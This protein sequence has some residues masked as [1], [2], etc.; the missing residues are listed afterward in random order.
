MMDSG[1][2]KTDNG[3]LPKGDAVSLP[4]GWEIKKLGEVCELAYGKP[5]DKSKRNQDGKYPVYGANGIKAYANEYYYD[6]T[7]MIDLKHTRG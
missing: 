5:L 3:Q 4:K 1:K 6:E 7:S 2:L